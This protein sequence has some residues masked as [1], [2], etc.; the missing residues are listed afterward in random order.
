MPAASPPFLLFV[1]T[2]LVI[3]AVD[4]ELGEAARWGSFGAV[5]VRLKVG[6][7]VEHQAA[8]WHGGVIVGPARGR[9]EP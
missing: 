1:G 3:K 9:G 8:K 5:C 7:G 6:M 4:A 2:T